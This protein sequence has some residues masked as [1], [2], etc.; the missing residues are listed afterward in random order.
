VPTKRPHAHGREPLVRAGEV[1]DGFPRGALNVVV[2]IQ[3]RPEHEQRHPG[4][5]SA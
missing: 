5:L 2:P 4:V 3:R 1:H